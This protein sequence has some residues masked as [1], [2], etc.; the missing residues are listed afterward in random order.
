MRLGARKTTV[1]VTITCVVMLSLAFAS[2]AS[3]YYYPLSQ[4][5]LSTSVNYSGAG[6]ITPS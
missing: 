5:S 2:T 4:C 1:F 6:Y 3:A